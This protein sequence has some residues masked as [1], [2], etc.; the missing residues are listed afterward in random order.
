[1]P[2]FGATVQLVDQAETP[3]CGTEDAQS[4]PILFC[5]AP[6]R[7]VGE[8]KSGCWSIP[9]RACWYVR[10]GDSAADGYHYRARTAADQ[11]AATHYRIVEVRREHKDLSLK[12]FHSATSRTNGS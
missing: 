8:V 3:L 11:L 5:A 10:T 2:I 6:S 4:A 1:V 7:L 9:S 12:F